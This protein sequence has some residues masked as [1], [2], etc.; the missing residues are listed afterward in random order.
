MIE[1]SKLIGSFEK[2]TDLFG[3]D[4]TNCFRLF[5]STGDGIEGLTIDV[6]GEYVLVQFFSHSLFARE[7]TLVPL[8]TDLVYSLPV[9]VRGMLLKNRVKLRGNHDFTDIRKSR[10]MKGEFPPGDYRVIQNGVLASVDLVE[11]QSTGIFLDMREIR[12]QIASLYP[13]GG[14]MLNLFCYTSI[15]SLHAL[16]NGISR[17]INVDLSKAVLRKSMHNYTINDVPY[18]RRDFIH[19]DALQWMK[20]LEKRGERFSFLVFDPPTFSR[21]RKKTF[22]VKKDYALAMEIAQKL[23]PRGTVLSSVNS[24]SV[25]EKEYLS[26]HPRNWE[27]LFFGNESCDFPHGGGPYLKAG[28][29]RTA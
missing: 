25:T 10:L 19:G 1:R 26:Y 22:S 16:K 17:C 13:P 20:R 3:M 4:D 28:L 21:N 5:N 2:R 15:F 27:P 24:H 9:R 11:G 7:H 18:D 23:C 8:L 6:Y 29:W 12:Q 14:R